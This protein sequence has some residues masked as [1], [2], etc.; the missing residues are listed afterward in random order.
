M[1]KVLG[2]RVACDQIR[3]VFEACPWVVQVWVCALEDSD[4]GVLC[5]TGPDV[6]EEAVRRWISE[7]QPQFACR[8]CSD[9]ARSAPRRR[10]R[11]SVLLP[12][13]LFTAV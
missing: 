13:F 1:V 8:M 3:R 12:S 9:A 7:H 2:R 6:T 10:C 4:V 11:R 5:S